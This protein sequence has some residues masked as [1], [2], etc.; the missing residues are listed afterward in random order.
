MLTASACALTYAQTPEPKKDF[1]KVQ[2]TYSLSFGGAGGYLGIETE[3]VSKENFAK[4]GLGEVR[5]VAV[6]K[7]IDG[8]PAQ[9]AGLQD[10]DVIVRFNDEEITSTR[11]LTRLIG[12]V[13]PDHQAKLTVS[14]GGQGREITVTLGKRPTPKFENGAFSFGVPGQLGRLQIPPMPPMP[15]M[16]AIPRVH[17]IPSMPE[18]NGGLFVWRGGASRRIGIGITPLTKQ[19]AESFGVSGGGMINNVRENSPAAKAGLKAGDIIVEVDGEP[20][21]SE[22]DLIRAIGEK[23]DGS[24]NLTFVRDRNRQTVTVTPEEVKGDFN[25]FFEG[26]QIDVL[27]PGRTKTIKPATPVLFNELYIPGRVL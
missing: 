26:S 22:I 13:A 16:G 19:L 23:K 5:G 6:E 15:P 4:Y 2:R 7:V 10:G 12:E 1:D 8:S 11:K 9:T 18:A 20:V 3:E 24:V 21:R 17:A 14:R 27:A 25:N